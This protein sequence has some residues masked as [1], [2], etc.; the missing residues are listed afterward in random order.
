MKSTPFLRA[1]PL[2]AALAFANLLWNP[3]PLRAGHSLEA[4]L[5]VRDITPTTPI[6]LAGYAARTRP[7]DQTEHP[8][9]V[10]ALALKNPT[11]ERVVFVALDNCEVSRA[12]MEPVLS[13]LE[14]RHQLAR[15][16]VM[17]V[18]SHSH[19][20]PVLE[21]TLIDMYKLT[22]PD[23]ERVVE[24]SRFLRAKLLE[25]VGA[26]L[27]ETAPALLEHGL[28]RAAFAMNRRV[29]R[30]DQVVFGENPDG[31]ADWDVPV[32]KVLDTNRAVRAVVFGYACHATSIHDDD[33]YTVCGDF[34]AFARQHVESLHPG[35]VALFLTGMG[36]DANPS[37]RGT[38][39]MSKRHGLEL[40]GAVVGVLDRPMRP[41]RGAFKLA[42]DEVELPFVDLPDRDKLRAHAQSQDYHLRHRAEKYLKWVEQGTAPRSI[43]LPLAVVRI[44]Q[45]LTFLAMGGEVVVDYARQFKRRFASDHPWTIGYA[46]EVPC[47]IPSAR[48]LKE[49]G[50]EAD[51]SLIYYGFYGPF[52]PEIEETILSRM[53]AL[54]AGVRGP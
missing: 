49:G 23:R 15:G 35:A 6:W 27:A 22:P 10:Q 18:S 7:S 16:T 44:G 31:P 5:A 37:P 14:R 8:L 54:L 13:E 48:L 38:L 36:G 25:V 42:Y 46:Y 26:A 29:Y 52:K 50:Y 20:T 19:S 33:F 2:L 12:F 34:M 3:P 39:L 1:T 17:V 24:Y 4:G 45:D 21:H 11:G 53:T 43:H 9:L 28:G 30:G 51:S 41:I 47:Y 40:A 32:L